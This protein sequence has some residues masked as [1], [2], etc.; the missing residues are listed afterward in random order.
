MILEIPARERL[1]DFIRAFGL[2]AVNLILRMMEDTT[3]YRFIAYWER[4]NALIFGGALV[5]E[6]AEKFNEEDA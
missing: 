5:E 2:D 1:E 4:E 6:L 3:E